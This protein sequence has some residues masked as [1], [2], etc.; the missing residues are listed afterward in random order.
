MKCTDDRSQC[1]AANN[2]AQQAGRIP[3]LFYQNQI[4]YFMEIRINWHNG[5]T[6]FNPDK[7]LKILKA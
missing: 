5:L 4:L 6:I 1:F 3:S 2:G 7:L